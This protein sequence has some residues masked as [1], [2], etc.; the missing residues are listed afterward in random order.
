MGTRPLDPTKDGEGGASTLP[1]VNPWVRVLGLFAA[2]AAA[3]LLLQALPPLVVLVLFVGGVVY[4]NHVLTARSKAETGATATQLPG[5]QIDRDDLVPSAYPFALFE[6]TWDQQVADAV[7]GRWNGF[8]V[9]LFDLSQ[10]P[11]SRIEGAALRR[12]FTC[13]IAMVPLDA[14]HTIVEP[15]AFL[16]EDAERPDLPV[17]GTGQRSLRSSFDVRSADVGF[18]DALLDPE[19]T[20][21]LLG[22]DERWAFEL[23]GRGLLCYAQRVPLKDRHLVLEAVTVLLERIARLAS[24]GDSAA[25]PGPSIPDPPVDVDP[26]V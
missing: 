24:E 5:L 22:Q 14:P 8:E 21:W 9:R 6:R 25:G 11:A 19:L 13:A 20:E 2:L 18:V 12:E 3:A 7:S 4:V 10:A 16:T 26:D 23:R 15:R 1:L 17:Q